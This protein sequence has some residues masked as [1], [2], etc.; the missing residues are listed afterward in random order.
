M[1][2]KGRGALPSLGVVCERWLE[3]TL[4]DAIS[5]YMEKAK[6]GCKS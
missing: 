3:P 1:N 2:E 6:N 4:V 5:D